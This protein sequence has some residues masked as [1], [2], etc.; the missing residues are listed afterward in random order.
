M[1]SLTDSR[2][3]QEALDWR[4]DAFMTVRISTTDLADSRSASTLQGH[5]GDEL[6][7]NSHRHSQTST[8]DQRRVTRP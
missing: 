6:G 4:C 3:L 2:L 7:Y 5:A 8:D 1:I